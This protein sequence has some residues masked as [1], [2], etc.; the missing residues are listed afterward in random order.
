M[1]RL[2]DYMSLSSESP[3][4]R[5]SADLKLKPY[6]RGMGALG[7][8]G[9]L[10]STSR[11]ARVAFTKLNSQSGDTEEES[12]S[13]FFH[14]LGSVDQQRGCCEVADGKYEI[15]LYTSCCNATKGIYYYTTYEN[16][17]ITAVDMY[18]ENLD[19]DRPVHYPL[20]Q[21]EHILLQNAAA[22]SA[23]ENQ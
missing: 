8:P 4:N 1:F 23:E 2:N 14:I 18:R 21:G 7:L 5:F 22:G 13:Q 12:V 10:S 15:T 9:D 6:S 3:T 16:H 20:V 17:Q 19:S 11:F